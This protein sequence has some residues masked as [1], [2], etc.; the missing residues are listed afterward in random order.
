M[1]VF[2]HVFPEFWA[3]ETALVQEIETPQR[4][5]R[6]ATPYWKRHGPGYD[7]GAHS[8]PRRALATKDAS[9]PHHWDNKDHSPAEKKQSGH[10]D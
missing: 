7:H 5:R 2:P 3:L 6:T 9:S 1:H 8:G 10:F 4:E